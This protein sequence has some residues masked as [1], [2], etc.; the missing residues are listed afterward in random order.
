M[1]PARAK[2]FEHAC[3]VPA[4]ALAGRT[5]N[6]TL[7]QGAALGCRLLG[8]QPVSFSCFFFNRGRFYQLAL[9]ACETFFLRSICLCVEEYSELYD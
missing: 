1:R 7:T 5:P 4:F 3:V 6:H 2:A 8:F 9:T